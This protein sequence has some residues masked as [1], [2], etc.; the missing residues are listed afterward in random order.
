MEMADLLTVSLCDNDA[1]G[2]C[3][4]VPATQR[5]LAGLLEAIRAH[6]DGASLPQEVNIAIGVAVRA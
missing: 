5:S 2:V 3:F 4:T 6:P 1:K